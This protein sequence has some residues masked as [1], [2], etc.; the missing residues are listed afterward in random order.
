MLPKPCSVSQAPAAS[1]R[2]VRQRKVRGMYRPACFSTAAASSQGPPTAGDLRILNRRLSNRSYGGAKAGGECGDRSRGLVLGNKIRPEARDQCPGACQ[3]TRLQ[4]A[5]VARLAGGHLPATEVFPGCGTGI[6]KGAGAER[7]KI[8]ARYSV[9]LW[10]CLPIQIW[11]RR[12]ADAS[13]A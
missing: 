13:C 10:R 5:Q 11:M 6:S 3:P 7:R 12:C 1:S 9:C 8:R 2:V 4:F